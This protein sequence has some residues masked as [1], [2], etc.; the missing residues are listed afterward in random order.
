MSIT[1]SDII[2]Y[3]D[4]IAN[5][6]IN[7]AQQAVHQYWWHVGQDSSQPPLAY[8][9][10]KTGTVYGIGVPI[11]G[12]DSKQTDPLQSAFY[13]LLLSAGQNGPQMPMGGPYITDEGFSVQLANGNTI[14][15][16]E[17]MGNLKEW[18]GNGYPE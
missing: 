12:T 15:G 7:N 11:I 4:A 18:L 14:T 16:A 1:Y 17:I 3:L 5:T 13:L 8:N 9:D 10:F 2:M 6:A